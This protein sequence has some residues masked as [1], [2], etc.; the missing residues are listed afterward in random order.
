M[1][2]HPAR[3]L[4]V[5]DGL[6]GKPDRAQKRGTERIPALSVS[7]CPR[8]GSLGASGFCL[9]RKGLVTWGRAPPK[10]TRVLK[11]VCRFCVSERRPLASLTTHDGGRDL[12]PFIFKNQFK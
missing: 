4:Q 3:G 2:T 5:T 6:L 12:A 8:P 7:R 11:S 9:C 10:Y 1:E